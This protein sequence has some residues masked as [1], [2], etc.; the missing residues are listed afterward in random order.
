MFWAV[1]DRRVTRPRRTA[2]YDVVTSD[3]IRQ[4]RIARDTL[5]AKVIQQAVLPV[6]P[7]LDR[8]QRAP[9]CRLAG[10]ARGGVQWAPARPRRWR[11]RRRPCGRPP[12]CESMV[13]M[14]GTIRYCGT[15]RSRKFTPGHPILRRPRWAAAAAQQG[16]SF[17]CLV[18]DLD[19]T[20]WGGVIGDDGLEGI[21][22][23]QGSALGEAFAAFQGYARDL[24]ER[25]IILAVCSKNDE[26]ERARALSS[27]HPDMVL[28]R[29][30]IACF[31]ANW[32]DKAATIRSIA[33][34]L[35]IGLD[36][37]VFVDD[38]PFERNFVRR[39]LPMV[40]VPEL[41]DDPALYAARAGRCRVFRGGASDGGGPGAQSA[42]SGQSAARDASKPP[43]PTLRAI[44]RASIWSCAGAVRPR[45]GG[46]G[47]SS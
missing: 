39:E 8:Q 23:G 15:G 47:S 42:I 11:G 6:F 3:L 7:P 38:N 41:P 40:A 37:L 21:V 10:V 24:S 4:W 46:S 35:R 14:P 18:L 33:E 45:S 28:K 43:R 26:A 1:F 36:S 27:K 31:L 5:G 22:L 17:K 12:R 16:R 13:W 44:S 34:E 19:N 30:D 2:A 32:E 29:G 9:P 20:L 25:G